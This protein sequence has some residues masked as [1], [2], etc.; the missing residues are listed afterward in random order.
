M[1]EEFYKYI[2]E[3]VSVFNKLDKNLP[4]RIISHLDAD[5]ITAASILVKTFLRE[6]RKFSVSIV[7]QI[8]KVRL[9]EFAK[10]DY[11]IFFFTDLG[12]NNISDLESL[13]N[14][15]NVFVLDH[16]IPEKKETKINFVNPHLFDI[17]G[18]HEISG[19]GVAYLFSRSINSK[20]KDL[21]HLP[22]IGAFGD[23]Q[24]DENLDSFVGLNKEI[25]ND[26]L[27]S[28]KLKIEKGLRLFGLHT[29]PIHKLLEYSTDP[30]IPN[31]TGD[32]NGTLQ[33]LN[34]LK[35]SLKDEN[36]TWRRACDLSEEEIKSLVTGIILRRMGSEENPEN[37][38]GNIYLLNEEDDKSIIKSA[39]EFSTL[40]NACGKM[41]KSDVGIGICLGDLNSKGEAEELL[42][43]YKKEIIKSLN[44]FYSN[45]KNESIKEKKNFV[46]INAENN[47]RDTLLGTFSSIISKSNLYED[48]TIV[49]AMVY[50]PDNEIKVS[51]RDINSNKDLR[52]ILEHIGTKLDIQFGGHKSA[53]G[54]LIPLEKEKEFIQL[55]E[56]NL[57]I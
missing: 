26:A 29:R 16:H 44:W 9:K 42:L 25:L 4:I 34:E 23:V 5:G 52:K 56:E 49:V 27:E 47:L 1:Y 22:I 8:S 35:I 14:G 41:D 53:A 2:E 24:Y 32:Y 28:N 51:I 21:S 30:F 13:F 10:E 7:K 20:N 12:S 40:L 17:D 48:G 31:V 57:E 38:F 15:R 18:S 45:R 54:C 43:Q 46:I 50:T 11:K 33:F 19:S 39:K 6:N 36:D 3:T 55:I 37:I